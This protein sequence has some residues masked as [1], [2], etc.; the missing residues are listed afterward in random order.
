[1]TWL[2]NKQTNKSYSSVLARAECQRVCQEYKMF[3][4][5]IQGH[6]LVENPDLFSLLAFGEMLFQ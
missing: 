4:L 6:N 5:I 1:M 3:W 2:G